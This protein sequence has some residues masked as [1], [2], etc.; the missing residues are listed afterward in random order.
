MLPLLIANGSASCRYAAMVDAFR[1]VIWNSPLE[2]TGCNENSPD[3]SR[4]SFAL[5]LA[6]KR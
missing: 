3:Q 4:R 2:P 1:A 5:V 6:L